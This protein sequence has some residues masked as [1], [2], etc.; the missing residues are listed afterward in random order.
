[1]MPAQRQK[2][3]REEKKAGVITLPIKVYS[4][5]LHELLIARGWIDFDHEIDRAQLGF[6]LQDLVDDLLR[7]A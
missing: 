6:A 1:M 4:A 3:H 7:D 2:N 5:A